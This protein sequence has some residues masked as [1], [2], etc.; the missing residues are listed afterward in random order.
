MPSTINSLATSSELLFAGGGDGAV[1]VLQAAALT[2]VNSI[3]ANVRGGSG[4]RVGK[5]RTE[6]SRGH[7]REAARE[8]GR[9]SAGGWRTLRCGHTGA[10]TVVLALPQPSMRRSKSRG[11]DVGLGKASTAAAGLTGDTTA[12]AGV[13]NATDAEAGGSKRENSASSGMKNG[14]GDAA[15]SVLPRRG[16]TGSSQRGATASVGRNNG[17]GSGGGGGGGGGGDGSRSGGS[18][19]SGALVGNVGTVRAGSA[20]RSG[21]SGTSTLLAT[22]SE[23]GTI[24]VWRAEHATATAT[25]AAGVTATATSSRKAVVLAGHGSAVRALSG[26]RAILASADEAGGVR[27][28]RQGS[29]EC[30]GVL[31]SADAARGC[32]HHSQTRARTYPRTSIRARARA[33]ERTHAPMLK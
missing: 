30:V 10:I 9:E 22:A 23:D 19:S 24:R 31:P 33:Q 21:S 1:Q 6:V 5:Q 20:A 27:L 16:L 4:S 13:S 8:N 2:A 15:S 28:W 29:W 11:V 18:S 32:A 26:T 14:G 3:S 12:A 17:G 25:A 7:S